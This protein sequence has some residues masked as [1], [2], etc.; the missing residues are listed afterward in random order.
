MEIR[1]NEQAQ[2]EEKV[3]EQKESKNKTA[4]LVKEVQRLT[5]LYKEKL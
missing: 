1:L 5:V 2:D 3:R 4:K